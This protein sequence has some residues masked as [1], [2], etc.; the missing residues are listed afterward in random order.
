MTK[1]IDGWMSLTPLSDVWQHSTKGG[2]SF[3]IM[4]TSLCISS[5]QSFSSL[6]VNS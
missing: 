2:L 1:N 4:T 3:R 5:I 6:Q